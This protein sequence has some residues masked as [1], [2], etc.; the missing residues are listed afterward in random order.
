M[1]ARG[2]HRDHDLHRAGRTSRRVRAAGPL[3]ELIARQAEA[4]DRLYDNKRLDN[5]HRL[6]PDDLLNF[7]HDSLTCAV[8]LGWDGARIERLPLRCELRDGY[9]VLRIEAGG[10]SLRV[11]TAVDAD[12]FAEL[13]LDTVAP[14]RP[15]ER[16]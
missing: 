7:H 14:R 5:A 16:P 13:W 12:R 8:A 3:G 15:A 4:H 9:P 2:D 11:V 6:L 10:T 1:A